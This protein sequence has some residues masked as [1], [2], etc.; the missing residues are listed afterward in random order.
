MNQRSVIRWKG[1]ECRQPLQGFDESTWSELL[2]TTWDGTQ[3]IAIM[4]EIQTPTKEK[5]PSR[6]NRKV[7]VD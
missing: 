5:K 1:E 2:V 6:E 4:N 3:P 7:G